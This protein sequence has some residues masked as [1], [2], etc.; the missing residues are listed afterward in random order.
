MKNFVIFNSELKNVHVPLFPS[1]KTKFAELSRFDL[2][3]LRSGTGGGGAF[4]FEF[5]AISVRAGAIA[6]AI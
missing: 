2:D 6:I 3:I 5:T 1:T 4:F